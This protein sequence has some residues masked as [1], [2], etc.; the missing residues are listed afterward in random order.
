MTALSLSHLRQSAAELLACVVTDLFPGAYMVNSSATEFGFYYDFIAEQPID[1]QALTLM[2]EKLRAL[3]K[4]NV[5]VR[6]LDMM[7]ENAAQF[8]EHKEQPFIAQRVREARENIVSIFQVG[9]FHDYCPFPHIAETQD[10]GAFK[11]LNV[12]ATT[13]FLL[14]EGVVPVIR[15]HGTAFPDTYALKKYLKTL[16]S[17]RKRDHR[18]LGKTLDLFA[19]H[20]DASTRAWFWHHNG[21]V[22]RE[23]L[24]DWWRNEHRKQHCSFLVTPPFVKD[25]L[26]QKFGIY[27]NVFENEYPPSCEIEDVDYVV[28]PTLSPVHAMIFGSKFHAH[29]D[30]PVRFAEC[31][32]IANTDKKKHL[33]G[34]FDAR[35]VYADY[36]H[37][38]CS[39]SQV[40]NELISSLQFIDKFTKIFNFE[41]HWYLK[42]QGQ[43]SAGQKVVGSD[44][45]WKKSTECMV[46]A[47]EKSGLNYTIDEAE[48]A[49]NGP[50]AEAR[51]ID[52]LGREWKGPYIGFDFNCPERLNLRYQEVNN[53]MQMP[54]MLVRSLFGSIERFVAILV[55]HYAGVLPV[56]LAPEQVRVI[57]VKEG[58]N[59]Y[60]QDVYT[61]LE[62]AGF[63]ATIDVRSESLGAKIHA[64]ENEKL[65]YMVIVG[66]KETKQHLI[67][68]RSVTK[69]TTQRVTTLEA[70]LKQLQQEV[71]TK[72]SSGSVCE[73][74]PNKEI[75]S[76]LES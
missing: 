64:A 4:Q 27:D 3:V 25:K 51:L 67:T 28:P 12:E 55:E 73:C 62:A 50:V 68:V 76:R 53:E 33:W 38:F 70:F 34:M 26:M 58:D 61:A 39:P 8:F 7:R 74:L 48:C 31:A 30:L 10:V 49:Y 14:E 43:R 57:P 1:M 9:E 15:I 66:E 40:E 71:S 54:L 63:R 47:F 18:Q 23:V 44:A 24:L 46:S 59:A 6:T 56:W 35:F 16:V 32:Y 65:P 22:L 72:A 29:R 21:A 41:Y 37:I 2:E 13:H 75:G 52:S 17:G 20:E 45:K 69:E 11:L 60:A 19:M 42:G 36:V 5:E